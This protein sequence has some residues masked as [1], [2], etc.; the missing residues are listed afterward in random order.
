MPD[1]VDW[2]HA[3]SVTYPWVAQGECGCCYALASIY[4]VESLI[5]IKTGVLEELSA[6]EIVSCDRGNG[7]KGCNGGFPQKVFEYIKRN[8][9][10]LEK[11]FPYKGKETRCRL[12]KRGKRVKITG[13][14]KVP[15]HGNG[16]ESHLLRAVAKQP[17]TAMIYVN[18]K[19]FY[20]YKDGIWRKEYRTRTIVDGA[21]HNVCIV[22]YH[23]IDTI[24]FWK[25]KNT[26]GNKW[27]MGGFMWIER[28]CGLPYGR[29]EILLDAHYPVLEGTEEEINELVGNTKAEQPKSFLN[30]FIP[31]IISRFVDTEQ[32]QWFND[33]K[34]IGAF[35]FSKREEGKDDTTSCSQPIN[36]VPSHL[37]GPKGEVATEQPGKSPMASAV[38]TPQLSDDD[39]GIS[40]SY[41]E[42]AI[43]K[44]RKMADG[45]LGG[46]QDTSVT[47]TDHRAGKFEV[48]REDC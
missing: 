32:F 42:T 16:D 13:H 24:K 31:L 46:G 48:N 30:R 7:N 27:G 14:V 17:V 39:I 22:G 20:K 25:I 38:A 47:I 36:S 5:H 19:E 34:E 41:A 6:Q 21:L 18:P 43:N 26:Y 35:L 15:C 44:N 3:R 11:D 12:S 28:D 37:V 2:H 33:L 8:G 40:P 1:E 4:A 45:V 10:S 29:C 23:T 9:I